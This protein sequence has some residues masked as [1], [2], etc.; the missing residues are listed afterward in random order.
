[1]HAAKIYVEN[2]A[3]GKKSQVDT[4]RRSH[5]PTASY[6]YQQL[7]GVAHPH[8][9]CT[10]PAPST[11]SACAPAAPTSLR[12][13]VDGLY[14]TPTENLSRFCKIFAIFR[15]NCFPVWNN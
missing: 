13:T 5:P 1:M 7:S 3:N 15:I 14:C 10:P 6:A 2:Y 11:Y 4:A 9:V 12:I 8:A